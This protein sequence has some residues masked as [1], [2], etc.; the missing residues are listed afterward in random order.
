MLKIGLVPVK[1]E[2]SGSRKEEAPGDEGC[3]AV[4]TEFG[5]LDGLVAQRL[6]EERVG[7]CIRVTVAADTVGRLVGSPFCTKIAEIRSAVCAVD[8]DRIHLLF[9]FV[10]GLGLSALR[11]FGLLIRTS[12]MS[13][14]FTIAT[15]STTS[16]SVFYKFAVIIDIIIIIAAIWI[17]SIIILIYVFKYYI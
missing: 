11:G 7:G 1:S 13:F 4:H 6:Q 3:A 2:E 8:Y 14:T 15:A 16:T 12:F 17:C 5:E 10:C 9:F